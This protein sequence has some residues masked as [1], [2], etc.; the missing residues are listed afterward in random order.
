MPHTDQQEDAL[1]T[2]SLQGQGLPGL[3]G[4]RPW[5]LTSQVYVA[6]FGGSLAVTGIAW[7]NARRLGA[8][9]P[10]RTQIL[11]AGLAGFAATLLLFVALSTDDT[12]SATRLGVQA[13]SIATYGALYLLQR[14][15]DRRYHWY[16]RRS[17]DESYDSLVGPGLIA[18]I[19]LGAV[20]WLLL[21]L[22]VQAFG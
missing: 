22:T 5:R 20:Q 11:L 21:V 7:L 10:R 3:H 2:P 6:F 16:D 15:L 8:T 13:I 19:A 18:V 1:L 12:P 4:P 9:S 14:Q 17:G